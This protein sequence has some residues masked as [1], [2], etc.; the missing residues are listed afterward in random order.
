MPNPI[1]EM[2]EEQKE[3]EAEKLAN[4]FDKLSR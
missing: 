4:M 1:E 3:R 2:T